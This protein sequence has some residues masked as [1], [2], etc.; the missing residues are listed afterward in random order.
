MTIDEW[1]AVARAD[2]ERRGL[3][4]LLPLLDGAAASARALRAAGLTEEQIDRQL[5]R[6]GAGGGFCG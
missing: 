5:I 1:L 2:A 4:D 3:P 6:S